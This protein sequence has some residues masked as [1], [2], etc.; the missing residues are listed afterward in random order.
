MK[1]AIIELLFHAAWKHHQELHVK[2]L[3]NYSHTNKIHSY[4]INFCLHSFMNFL[5]YLNFFSLTSRQKVLF[6][7]IIF[8]EV[9]KLFFSL[10]ILFYLSKISPKI[11]KFFIIAVTER[12]VSRN[13]SVWA[14]AKNCIIF[15]FLL[16]MCISLD[17]HRKK[18][19]ERRKKKIK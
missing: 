6:Y 19:A 18:T 13:L 1:S 4:S 10:N 8:S 14:L 3:L 11:Y 5:F 12:T 15:I 7:L 2:Y 16:E 9:S 17:K